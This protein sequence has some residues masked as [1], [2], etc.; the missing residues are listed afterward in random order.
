MSLHGIFKWAVGRGPTIED[1][2][3]EAAAGK[4]DSQFKLATFYEH[5]QLGL[6]QDYAEAVRWYRKAAE[7][8]HHAAQLYLGICLALG[9]GVEPDASQALMW[10]LLAKRGGPFDRA[11]ANETQGRLE[12]LMSEAQIGEARFMALQFAKEHGG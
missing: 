7:Q 12:G 3:R 11:A 1:C 10:V 4:A 6:P 5:G 8:D 2:K 9:R